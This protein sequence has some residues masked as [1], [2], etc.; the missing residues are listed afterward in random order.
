LNALARRHL[1]AVHREVLKFGRGKGIGLEDPVFAAAAAAEEEL[2]ALAPGGVGARDAL[3]LLLCMGS[4]QPGAPANKRLPRFSI[5]A[6]SKPPKK[7][8]K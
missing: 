7:S 4:L 8:F 5:L 3:R 6:L 1:G 2:R